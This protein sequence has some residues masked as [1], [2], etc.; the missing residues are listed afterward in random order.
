VK[1]LFPVNTN[2]PKKTKNPR[3]K[4]QEKSSTV[5]A[6]NEL[7]WALIGL[8]LTIFSTFIEVFFVNPPWHWLDRG[9][10]S[11]PLGVTYQ[12]GAVLLAGCLGGKNAGALSQIAYVILG[13]T[14]LPIF[15][16]GG[17]LGYFKEPSFGYILGFIPGAWLCG[18][19]AFRTRVKLE[20][21]TFSALAGLLVIHLCG[22][23]YLLGLALLHKPCLV[24]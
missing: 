17:G 1:P 15:A 24:R 16:H 12:V 10:F 9:V 7:I 21:L 4:T 5:S 22:L 8:L 20:S 3:S 11:Q 13:L 14:W 19:I 18:L 2:R 6:P 23:V